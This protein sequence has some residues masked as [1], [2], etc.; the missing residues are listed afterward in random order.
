MHFLGPCKGHNGSR[1]TSYSVQIRPVQA[2]PKAVL[3]YIVAFLSF[4]GFKKK[5][6]RRRRKEKKKEKERERK[7]KRKEKKRKRKEKKKERK[8]KEKRV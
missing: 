2:A 4:S 3:I 6:R 1:V 5:K 7:R 8:G